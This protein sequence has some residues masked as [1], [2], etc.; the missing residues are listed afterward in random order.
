MKDRIINKIMINSEGRILA[1][2]SETEDWSPQFVSDVI[3]DIESGS[4]SYCVYFN[5]S[6]IPVTIKNGENGKYPFASKGVDGNNLINRLPIMEQKEASN[7]AIWI[8]GG[9]VTFLGVSAIW[10]IFKNPQRSSIINNAKGSNGIVAK[11]NGKKALWKTGLFAITIL[12]IALIKNY[13]GENIS[14]INNVF[15][16][17]GIL[18]SVSVVLFGTYE[19]F[20]RSD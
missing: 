10:D 12:A 8:L 15:V 4:H 16:D 6:K 14:F 7:F 19:R 5:N 13:F 2:V 17:V 9:F 20:K 3:Y 11:S 1:V 18:V